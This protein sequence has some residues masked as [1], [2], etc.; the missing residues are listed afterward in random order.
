MDWMITIYIFVSWSRSSEVV[1]YTST[2]TDQSFHPVKFVPVFIL[3]V[4]HEVTVSCPGS[5]LPSH[6]W[7]EHQ[8]SSPTL[9]T[10]FTSPRQSSQQHHA[11]LNRAVSPSTALCFQLLHRWAY[12]G[13]FLPVPQ[14]HPDTHF[15]GNEHPSPK[16]RGRKWHLFNF[17]KIPCLISFNIYR[18]TACFFLRLGNVALC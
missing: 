2:S 8:F 12:T 17:L 1:S 9:L 18:Y 15:H 5:E 6:D 11:F 7:L 4:K 14:F 13:T 3:H 16:E 10:S